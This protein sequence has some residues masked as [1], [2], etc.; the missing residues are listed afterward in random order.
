MKKWIIAVNAVFFLVWAGDSDAVRASLK[1]DRIDPGPTPFIS[2]ITLQISDPAALA[3]IKFTVRPKPLSQT[4]AIAATYTSAYLKKQDYFNVRTGR[5][6]LP[7]FGL[8]QNFSNTITVRSRFTDGTSQ[9]LTFTVATPDFDGGIF[10]S[11]TI[12][13]AR[14]PDTTLS[15]DFM[16][17]KNTI[18]DSTPVIIDSDAEIR[19]V[20]TA[21]VISQNSMLFENGIYVAD[22]TSLVREEFDGRYQTLASYDSLGVTDFHHNFD[23]GRDGIIMDVDTVDWTECVNI[24]VDD[25]GN[26]LRTWNLADII[27]AAM[28]AGGDNPDD[29]LQPAPADWFHNNATA[30]RKSDNSLIVSSRENFVI[31]IDYDT[32][33]IKW[34]L[35]DPTKH[36]YEFPSLRA[37][38]LALAPDSLPPIGQHA[39][40]FFHDEL[41]LFDDG[42]GSL[43]Q[44][45]PGETRTYS[46]PRRYAIAGN[47]A[48]E[49]WHYLADPPIDS[50]FCSSVYEDAANNYFIDYTLAGPNVSTD[51]VGLDAT[52][53]VAFY[54]QYPLVV[55][56][57]T[58]WNA[59]PIHLEDLRF[60]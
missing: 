44:L 59:V 27:S 24:E 11:P 39:V 25:A 47:T 8:Y 1:L 50:P 15:Y 31:A 48:T 37:F 33:A 53:S 20:G 45:P 38:S 32:G 5:L 26:V 35:G 49:I 10:D 40:S 12:V 19:W 4:R 60:N 36:W 22:G 17:L 54:Y 7:V 18:L 3:S 23:F 42:E 13:Q 16:L 6:T 29:F 43:Y 51:L 34:I 58:A 14:L 21:P 28:I 46:A 2:F 30:Y 55:G 9:Q 52:G 56:C 57:G 41:L